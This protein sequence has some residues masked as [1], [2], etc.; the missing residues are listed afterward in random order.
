V[1]RFSGV[2]NSQSD[3]NRTAQTWLIGQGDRMD[4]QGPFDVVPEL[5]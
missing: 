3:A 5:Q 1:Y 4:D 2:G